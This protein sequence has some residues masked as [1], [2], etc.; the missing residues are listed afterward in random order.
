MSRIPSRSLLALALAGL[1]FAAPVTAGD[2]GLRRTLRDFY[3]AQ[4]R[5]DVGR[6]LPRYLGDLPRAP[7]RIL[8]KR[9]S[10]QWGSLAPD[11]TLSLD[12]AAG[13][14]GLLAAG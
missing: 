13:A 5:A 3:E 4:G 2:A 12:L 1:L 8:F 9:T 10:S 14:D 6:W 11:G 7:R